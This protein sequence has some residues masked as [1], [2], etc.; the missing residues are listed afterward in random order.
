MPRLCL[1]LQLCAS[2]AAAGL[3][4]AV[5][6]KSGKT[7]NG[8]VRLAPGKVIVGDT[9]GATVEL[10]LP[11]L[12]LYRA[13]LPDAATNTL[14]ILPTPP[15]NGLLGIYY[16]NP[17][18]TGEFFKTR[19][20]PA[21]DFDWGHSAPLPDM[22]SNG[23]SV[24][25]IG[26]IIAPVTAHYTFHSIS[27]GGVRL[28]INNAP[29]IDSWHDRFQNLTTPPL[30]LMAGQT[31]TFRM[32]VCDTKDRAIARLLWSSQSMPQAI[33][34]AENLIPADNLEGMMTRVPKKRFA[35][36]VLTVN[37]SLIPGRVE[38]ADRASARLAGLAQP[39]S[40]IQIARLIFSPV[41]AETDSKL[42]HGRAG[43]L[44]KSGDFVEGDFEGVKNGQIRVSS[45]VLGAKTINVSQA[46]AA[47]LRPVRGG[48]A[49]FEVKTR[50]DGL[51]R[52]ARLDLL[53][54]AVMVKDAAFPSIKIDASDILEIRSEANE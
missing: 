26:R 35:S 18:C 54:D 1:A 39:L 23:F 46:I 47:V 30:V 6:T 34:P 17:D 9:N 7:L 44:L 24:R 16:N 27:D 8:D 40:I 2:V 21:I 3:P 53:D 50:D 14:T 33:V 37:G 13:V 45:V 15:A 11:A 52:A 10:T 12:K 28:W 22:N 36:G 51:F 29:A 38:S 43:V 42:A 20:D 49:N 5:E 4:G 32:E 31:N 48:A 25:W 19:F 41:T